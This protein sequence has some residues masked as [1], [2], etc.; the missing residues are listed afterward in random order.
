MT[1]EEYRHRAREFAAR[2]ERVGV[3]K[4]DENKVR[5]IRQNRQGLTTRA[6]ADRLGVHYRTVE[7]VRYG[8]TWC[9]ID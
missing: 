1:R 5:W 6:M 8:E 7:K 9:H 3:A 2:G 4:L